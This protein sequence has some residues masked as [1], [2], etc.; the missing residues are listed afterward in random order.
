MKKLPIGLVVP[1]MLSIVKTQLKSL[2]DDLSVGSSLYCN[3]TPLTG[4][5]VG[6]RKLIHLSIADTAVSELPENLHIQD[7][8]TIDNTTI[9]SLPKGLFVGHRLGNK[10]VN[11]NSE[12]DEVI[13]GY[14]SFP[15]N[16]NPRNKPKNVL[17][18]DVYQSE[19]VSEPY[20]NS[21]LITYQGRDYIL[22]DGFLS[23]VIHQHGV[24]FQIGNPYDSGTVRYLVTDGKGDWAHGRNLGEAYDDLV[25]K[26]GSGDTEEYSK[27][28]LDSILSYDEAIVCYRV[29]TRACRLGVKDFLSKLSK[30]HK[31]AYTVKEIIEL[32]KGTMVIRYLEISLR[33]RT[34]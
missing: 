27:L 15:C 4:I 18:A 10:N 31:K 5:P 33:C 25:Y 29:I 26:V 16:I 32:R 24:I 1:G 21:K 17:I 34:S 19:D 12:A 8:L 23:E 6:I 3:G 28:S 14:A 11:I 9:S 30:P 7:T 2:P 22:V 13:V 20:P